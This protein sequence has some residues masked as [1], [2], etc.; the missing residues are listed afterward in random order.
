MKIDYYIV[1]IIS[2]TPFRY[3]NDQLGNQNI[4]ETLRCFTSFK[5]REN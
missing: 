4:A 2:H 3:L 1:S 5:T